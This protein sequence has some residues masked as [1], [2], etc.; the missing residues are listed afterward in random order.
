MKK[1]TFFL[2]LLILLS[3]ALSPLAMAVGGASG[4]DEGL[5]VPVKLA[6]TILVPLLI[7]TILCLVWKGQMKSAIAAR[8]ADHYIPENGF[9]LTQKEDRFLYKTERRRKIEKKSSDG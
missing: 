1:T 4:G 8:T 6:I 2:S 3:V 7:A 5:S 9:Q